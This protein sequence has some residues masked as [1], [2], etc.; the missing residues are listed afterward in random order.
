MVFPRPS[1][2][3]HN[4][5]VISITCSNKSDSLCRIN[6]ANQTFIKCLNHLLELCHNSIKLLLLQK[7]S[8][9]FSWIKPSQKSIGKNNC[10]TQ[11]RKCSVSSISFSI[12]NCFVYPERLAKNFETLHRLIFLGKSLRK[13]TRRPAKGTIPK[14]PLRKV[15]C[16]ILPLL[17]T[18]WKQFQYYRRY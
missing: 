2:Q 5:L 1:S 14:P 6:L 7:C 9:S 3:F 13:A 11:H 15:T 10:N 18:R 12:C 8:T 4:F 17:Q 16:K